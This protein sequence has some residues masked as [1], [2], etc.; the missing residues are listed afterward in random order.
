VGTCKLVSAHRRR[1][2]V[3]AQV[4][5]RAATLSPP[6]GRPILEVLLKRR[7]ASPVPAYIREIQPLLIRELP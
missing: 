4:L 5:D 2:P 6:N 1:T 7:S 3:F